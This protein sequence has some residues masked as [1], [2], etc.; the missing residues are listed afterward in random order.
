ML[1]VLPL[2]ITLSFFY[3]HG[4]H[5]DLHS[6]PTRRSSDLTAPVNVPEEVP[7]PPSCNVPACAS[8]VPLLL[9]SEVPASEL[10][11]LT[12]LV[13]RPMLLNNEMAPPKL[14]VKKV[15]MLV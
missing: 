9:R 8:M 1:L 7:P 4:D 12:I 10:A 13:C 3:S 14:V 6:F 5:R 11:S 15:E 2:T